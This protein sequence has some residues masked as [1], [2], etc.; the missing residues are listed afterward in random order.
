[1]ILE[2]ISLDTRGTISEVA[3]YDGKMYI[4]SPYLHFVDVYAWPS[5]S[6]QEEELM[7]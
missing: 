5:K 3:V 6:H 1:M 2:A 4:G 7:G